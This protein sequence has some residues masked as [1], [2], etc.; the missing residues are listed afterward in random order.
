M[1][2]CKFT[3][4]EPS[5]EEPAVS[6]TLPDDWFDRV[7]NQIAA[8]SPLST[9]RTHR[10]WLRDDFE[11]EIE[12]PENLT[13]QEMLRLQDFIGLLLVQKESPVTPTQEVW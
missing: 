10:L 2:C 7:C 9:Y 12:L 13:Q 4:G 1:P 11:V 5:V 6:Q 3:D 8:L